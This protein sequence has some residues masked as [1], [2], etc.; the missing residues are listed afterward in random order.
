M[1]V[2]M[3]FL[4]GLDI[5]LKSAITYVNSHDYVKKNDSDDDLPLEKLT[6]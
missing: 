1:K 2:M 6:H 3:L 5:K 4:M